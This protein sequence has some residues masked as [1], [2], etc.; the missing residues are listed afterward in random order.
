M[1]LWILHEVA[2][3]EMHDGKQEAELMV[4]FNVIKKT[5]IRKGDNLVI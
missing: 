2:W 4:S 3:E 5:F 1:C